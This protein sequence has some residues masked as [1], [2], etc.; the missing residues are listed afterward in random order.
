LAQHPVNES[1]RNVDRLLSL[2]QAAHP[3]IWMES[4]T[5]GPHGNVYLEDNQVVDASTPLLPFRKTPG[6]FW[7]FNDCRNTTVLGYAY[8]ETQR[9]KYDSDESYQAEVTS[10]IS[11]LYG[12]RSRKQL[13]TQRVTAGSQMLL[14]H[15]NTFTDWTIESSVA[16]SK[17]PSTFIVSFSLISLFQSDP[18]VDVGSWMVLLPEHKNEVHT[19]MR[20]TTK[21]KMLNGTT[22]I[23]S[24]LIDQVNAGMLASLDEGDVVPYLREYLTWNVYRVSLVDSLCEIWC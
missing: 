19:S 8:P 9:W 18:S 2:Y 17:F 24:H 16:A 14:S 7:T 22:S 10:T 1:Y 13:L 20:P 4:S 6:E 11:S 21:E 12:G 3:D 5:I 15:N 23:T